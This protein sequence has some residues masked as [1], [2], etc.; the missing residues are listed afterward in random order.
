M[1][2]AGTLA[3]GQQ[4]CCYLGEYQPGEI[5]VQGDGM[6]VEVTGNIKTSAGL[7]DPAAYM[8]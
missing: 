8:T 3:K 6:P 5:D 1:A 7:P 2:L 4:I